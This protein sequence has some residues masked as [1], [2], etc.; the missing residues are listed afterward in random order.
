[1]HYTIYILAC[2]FFVQAEIGIEVEAPN[3]LRIRLL[4]SVR[5]VE[6]QDSRMA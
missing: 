5:I 6:G 3:L 2:I 4:G 1:M